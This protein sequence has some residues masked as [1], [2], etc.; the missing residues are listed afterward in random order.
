MAE[1]AASL[2]LGHIIH[3][4]CPYEWS[5]RGWV[6]GRTVHGMCLQARVNDVKP[7]DRCGRHYGTINTFFAQEPI[8]RKGQRVDPSPTV[9]LV[10][11]R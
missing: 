4:G 6:A 9:M 10:S 1:E 8:T 2:L 7:R 5:R 3:L 11:E